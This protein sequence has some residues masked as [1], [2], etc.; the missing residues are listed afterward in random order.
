MNKKEPVW[1]AENMNR[2]KG[3]TNFEMCGWCR[4]R[5]CGSYRYDCMIS[6]DCSLLKNYK[7]E[8]VWNTPC[9]IKSL[10][11]LDLLDL[12][13]SKKYEIEESK[14]A[15]EIAEHEMDV[16]K[17][18]ATKAKDKPCLPDSR[19]CEHFA[20]KA[21]VRVFLDFPERNIKADWYIGTVVNG[22]R[23]GDGCVSYV[24]DKLPESKGG[25]GCGISAPAVILN[26]EYQYFKKNPA[27]F[28]IWLQKSDRDY[29]GQRIIT[30]K[31][32]KLV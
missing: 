6:G 7:N 3:D 26:S 30:Q 19:T 18:L 9:K 13:S 12:A 1:N 4:H 31:M 5:G 27:E 11:K 21:R 17:K 14:R 10:G 2:K 23:S 16:L 28:E 22:Y 29:N 20:P 25:W 15:I 8:T 24:L 32:R